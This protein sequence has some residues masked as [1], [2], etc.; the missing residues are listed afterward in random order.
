VT[1]K[2]AVSKVP[3]W[4]VAADGDKLNRA[5]PIPIDAEGL[6]PARLSDLR[7]ALSA[8]L[9]TCSDPMEVGRTC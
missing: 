6:T 5:I 9:D 4:T 7:N 3:V 2:A 8:L 1:A